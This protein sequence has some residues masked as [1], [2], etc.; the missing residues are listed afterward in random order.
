[1]VNLRKVLKSVVDFGDSEFLGKG[2]SNIKVFYYDYVG[3]ID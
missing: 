3:V 1:M 2:V